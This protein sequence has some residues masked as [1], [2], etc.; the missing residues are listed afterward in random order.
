MKVEAIAL[1]NFVHD[2]IRATEGKP[3]FPWIEQHLAEEFER[4]G[5]VRIRMPSAATILPVNAG[6]LLAAGVVQPSSVLPAAPVSPSTT[7]H[8]PKCGAMQ[9]KTGTR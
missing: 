9:R 1:T 2:R 4:K 3:I 6:N 7:L 8:L 5:L